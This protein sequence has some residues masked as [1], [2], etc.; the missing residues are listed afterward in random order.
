MEFVVLDW[1]A[2]CL[3]RSELFFDHPLQHTIVRELTLQLHQ[4]LAH[5][6]FIIR[7]GKLSDPSLIQFCFLLLCLEI[8]LPL[9]L[10]FSLFFL[11][12]FNV[13]TDDPR[14]IFWLLFG[15]LDPVN[16]V[17]LSL[18]RLDLHVV[19]LQRA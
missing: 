1:I 16:E 3:I 4:L 2:E 6:P 17:N 5:L 7:L 8:C 19:V 10:F 14:A 18:F 9:A 15:R 11:F 12:P 13:V